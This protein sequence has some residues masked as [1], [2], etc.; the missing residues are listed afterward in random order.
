M[1]ELTINTL[2]GDLSHYGLTTAIHSNHMFKPRITVFTVLLKSHGILCVIFSLD[3][4]KIE[5]NFLTMYVVDFR[6]ETESTRISPEE[7]RHVDLL[8]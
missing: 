2:D 5:K 3:Y 1:K 6:F 7:I 4:V 8:S